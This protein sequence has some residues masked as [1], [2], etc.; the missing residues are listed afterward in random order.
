MSSAS[1]SLTSEGSSNS[2]SSAPL[3]AR[4]EISFTYSAVRTEDTS[5]SFLSPVNLA[6][7]R[8]VKGPISAG[9]VS[10]PI[11]LASRY[12]STGFVPVRVITVSSSISGTR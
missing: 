11:C 7:L 12:S 6:S 8:N 2:I 9:L 10:T 4:T 5:E 3:D 1:R